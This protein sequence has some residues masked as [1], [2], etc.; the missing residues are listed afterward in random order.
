MGAQHHLERGPDIPQSSQHVLVSRV[1]SQPSINTVWGL[2]FHT[3]PWRDTQAMCP[4]GSHAKCPSNLL[5]LLSSF[6]WFRDLWDRQ[7]PVP[8]CDRAGLVLTPEPLGRAAPD[9]TVG[10][11]RDN[12]AQSLLGESVLEFVPRIMYTGK[13][14]RLRLL[15]IACGRLSSSW[16]GRRYC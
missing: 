2:G 4:V 6:K 3:E 11:G 14:Q 9:Q 7:G 5:T 12:L 8:W 16:A 15:G 13:A 1:P 10:R